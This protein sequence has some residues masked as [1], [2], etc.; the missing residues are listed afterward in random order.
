MDF[1]TVRGA[2]HFVPSSRS[3]EALQMLTNFV[4]NSGNYSLLDGL[5]TAPAPLRFTSLS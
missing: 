3:H 5:D 1:V 2:G 4:R